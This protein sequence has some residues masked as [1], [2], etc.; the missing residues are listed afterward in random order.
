MNPIDDFLSGESMEFNQESAEELK[1]DSAALEYSTESLQEQQT[2]DRE[3]EAAIESQG[4]QVDPGQPQPEQS[5]TGENQQQ[6]QQQPPKEEASSNPLERIA[7]GVATAGEAIA[8]APA[9]LLDFGADMM[10]ALPKNDKMEAVYAANRESAPDW[11]RPL[12]LD[13]GNGN[14]PKLPKYEN[15]SVQMARDVIS[16]IGPSLGLSSGLRQVGMGLNRRIGLGLGGSQFVR[17]LGETGVDAASGAAIDSINE[18]SE[19][20][21]LQ[22]QLREL[23]NTPENERLFG[24]F[25]PDWATMDDDHS[26]LK[27]RKNRDEGIGLAIATGWIPGS[28][29]FL[30]G[31]QGIVDYF[32]WV[33]ENETAGGFFRRMETADYL[34]PEQAT[35]ENLVYAQ[36]NR[37][38]EAL[39]DLGEYNLGRTDA[40]FNVDGPQLGVSNMYGYHESGIRSRD[41]MGAVGASVDAVRIADNI[42]SS[43]GRLGSMGTDSWLK[44][45]LELDDGGFAIVRGIQDE[46]LE[47]GEYGYKAGAKGNRYIS[48]KRIVE[49]GEEMGAD[50]YGMSRGE[51]QRY[52]DNLK[53][54]V[55]YGT[56]VINDPGYKAVSTAISK[57]TNDLMN[58]DYVRAMGYVDTSFAGQ[59]SD[60]AEGVR[61]MDG[62]AVM[63]R[64]SEEILD[65]LQLLMVTKG[66]RSFVSG[67]ALNMLNWWNRGF[68]AVKNLGKSPEQLAKEFNVEVTEGLKAASRDAKNTV[69]T[70]RNVAKERPDMLKPLLM[71]YE[72]TD[73]K[74]NTIGKLNDWI[75]K[76][77]GTLSKAVIDG[78]TST[79]SLVLQGAWANVYNS[80]LSAGGTV[81]KAAQ[82]T[83]V[84]LIQKPV[85]T[86]AGAFISGD[87]RQIA[88]AVYQYKAIQE[89]FFEKAFPYMGS[90]FRKASQNPSEVAW[91]MKDD[92]VRKNEQSI[93]VLKAAA[94]V[95]AKDG[96]FGPQMMVEIIEAQWDM[97]NN[98][99]LK[100]GVNGMTAIDGFSTS[101]IANIEARGRAFDA[102][103]FQGLKEYDETTANLIAKG[104]YDEMWDKNTGQLTDKAVQWASREINMNLKDS[105]VEALSALVNKAPILKPFFMFP[106]TSSSMIRFADSMSPVSVFVREHNSM[107][108]K[109]TDAFNEE[110]ISQILTSRGITV[111]ETARMK[112]ES[113]VAEYRGRKAIGYMSVVAG[114]MLFMQDRLTGDGEANKQ[115]RRAQGEYNRPRRSVQG[116][117]GKWY[118]YEFLGPAADLLA[119]QANTMEAFTDLSE[120][121]FSNNMSRVMW[122]TSANLTGKSYLSTLEP[123]FAVLS[124]NPAAF[125]RF[126][127]QQLNAA[128]PLAGM[129]SELARI[130]SPERRVIEDDLADNIM[131]RNPFGKNGLDIQTSWI[132]GKQIKGGMGFWER[133]MDQYLPWK[134]G[135]EVTPA[136][137]FLIDVEWD[138]RPS[139][140]TDGYGVEYSNEQRAELYRLMGE[141]KVFATGLKR[142][143][144]QYP[145]WE[146]D[147]RQAQ[148][149]NSTV[150]VDPK[151]YKNLHD[152]LNVILEKAKTAAEGAME[153]RNSV[154]TQRAVNQRE[155]A[156]L[157]R[158]D[159]DELNR[160]RSMYH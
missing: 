83:G 45:G 35:P 134:V 17:N 145:D 4:V 20:H 90:V 101:V 125:N 85:A 107:T 118:S 103:T 14:A 59:V 57:L 51:M 19:G 126:A 64:A 154:L 149:D 2:L 43:Y 110:E 61:M 132:T 3:E 67:R 124:G 81:L 86:F 24:I 70:L 150:Y 32:K 89:T 7:Q 157:Q 13:D 27:R 93:A 77:T 63:D 147:I 128:V 1:N 122:I 88:R 53:T 155:N 144:K 58:M 104:A 139:L 113:L 48:M 158:G 94:D 87:K 100:W 68:D 25:P 84:L 116:L 12:M 102:V 66:Q 46:L 29:K 65:R 56:R 36:G 40:D 112:F 44:G 115:T 96:E 142:L 73:G 54:E 127:A 130:M 129:R 37:V 111:D 152:Q 41:P 34:D 23:L 131:N 9:G 80:I 78:D 95:A 108:Y 60:L 137:Q 52:L 120:K 75:K 91:L 16:F 148:S 92:F 26:D 6:Q 28:A 133:V 71:A 18:N 8:K 106:K 82:A 11:A 55:N 123:L 49:V 30:R 22:G 153:D 97:A 159:M 105:G 136:E 72:M 76:S 50:L 156:A 160:L 98:P 38:D 117:D 141:Q 74:V 151:K 69:D 146:K 39:D 138:A 33:P 10:N 140:Q 42:D 62:T 135:V 119:A 15:E 31:R 121:D 114:G 99:V 79:P 143:M 5:P 109:P 21:N 47:A